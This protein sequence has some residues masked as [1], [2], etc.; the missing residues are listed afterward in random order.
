MGLKVQTF[1]IPGPMLVTPDRFGDARGFFSE[2]YNKAAFAGI[3]ITLDFVQDNHSRSGDVGTI[4]G[5]HFQTPPYAQDKLIRVPRGRIFDVIVD[6][7]K[8]SPHFGKHISVDLSAENWS[9]LFVPV[10]FAHGLC[11]LEPDTE[12]LY[13]VSAPYAPAHD[14]GIRWNDP[15]LAIAWPA[16]AGSQVSAKDSTLPLLA[17]YDSPFVFVP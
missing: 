16:L 12:V 9:Q 15:A 10:G 1:A 11:T 13:K 8:G 2:T 3:G 7:R 5:I 4:R 17:D 6:L 14:A